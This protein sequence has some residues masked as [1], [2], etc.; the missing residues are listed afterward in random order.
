MKSRL[1]LAGV[2]LWRGG[3]AFVAAWL[4]YHGAWQLLSQL[5]WPRQLTTGTAL[6]AGGLALVLLSLI[7][8]R[9]AAAGKEGNL[10]DE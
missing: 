9:V 8:E 3:L 2:I 4:F 5:D 6:I 7:L 1:R 10:L